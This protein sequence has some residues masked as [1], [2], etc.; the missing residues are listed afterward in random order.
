MHKNVIEGLEA[1]GCPL[2]HVYFNA[3]GKW[4]GKPLH[5]LIWTICSSTMLTS[6]FSILVTVVIEA[7]L[8]LLNAISAWCCPCIG[9]AVG[10]MKTPC[11]ESDPR[12]SNPPSTEA[13]H[14]LKLLAYLSLLQG[15]LL[16]TQCP[17]TI[18]IANGLGSNCIHLQCTINT[19][20]VQ[21]AAMAKA[22]AQ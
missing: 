11:H 10:P 18:V 21:T 5:V 20:A 22:H 1:A 19:C 17:C 4:Y 8:N 15:L 12:Y 9:Q 3:G 7:M 2:Q 14:V 6:A 16:G 13:N